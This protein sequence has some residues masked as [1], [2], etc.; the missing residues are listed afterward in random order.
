MSADRLTD[1]PGPQ[2]LKQQAIISVQGPFGLEDSKAAVFT[3]Q[4]AQLF[5]ILRLANVAVM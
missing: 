4:K 3:C 1:S 5:V 2:P